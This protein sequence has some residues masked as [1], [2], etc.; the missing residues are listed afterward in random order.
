M[1]DINTYTKICIEISRGRFNWKTNSC[2][3]F[4]VYTCKSLIYY[5]V[6]EKYMFLNASFRV[7]ID[8]VCHNFCLNAI[9][10]NV[11]KHG[12]LTLVYRYIWIICFKGLPWRFVLDVD[13]ALSEIDRID[14]SFGHLP[15]LRNKLSSGYKEKYKITSFGVVVGIIKRKQIR[16][17]L[18]RFRLNM[19]P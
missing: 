17:W 1:R 9:I 18:Y 8:N 7:L 3:I 12:C 10:E 6:V 14:L 16:F 5:I 19:H 15:L 11:F 4:Q 2:K 13:E